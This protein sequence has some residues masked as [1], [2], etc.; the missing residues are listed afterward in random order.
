MFLRDYGRVASGK[1]EE[2][3]LILLM[4]VEDTL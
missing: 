2:Y 3:V 1:G 4:E